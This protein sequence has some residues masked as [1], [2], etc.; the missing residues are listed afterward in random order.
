MNIVATLTAGVVGTEHYGLDENGDVYIFE[1]D[2]HGY[3]VKEPLAA[4]VR[5]AIK[6]GD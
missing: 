4:R 1:A 3:K 5:E 2:G 6:K